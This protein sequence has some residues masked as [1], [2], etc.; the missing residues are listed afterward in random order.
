MSAAALAGARSGTK[1]Q[2][3]NTGSSSSDVAR[4]GRKNRAAR[5]RRKTVLKGLKDLEESS[6]PMKTGRAKFRI[7]CE[8][9]Q[10]SK[11]ATI[12]HTLFGLIILMSLVFMT[13]E[14]LNHDGVL[15]PGNLAPHQYKTMEMMF[16]VMFTIDLLFRMAIADRFFIKRRYPEHL[17]TH[18]PFFRDLLNWFDFLSILPLP[19]DFAIATV[20]EGSAVPKYIRLL[21]VFRVLRIFK[22]TRHFEGTKII[23]KTAQSSAAP[24]LVS[25]FMLLSFMFV[26]SPI[27]FFV[28]PCHVKDECVFHDAFN[29]MYYLMITLTTVGYGDQVCIFF[30]LYK[31]RN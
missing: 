27:L 26:V 16:T 8:S 11:G 31:K 12:F 15:F 10:S 6:P 17:E 13:G 29:S 30:F 2:P 18:L 20:Y 19:I 22:V 28:E 4:D 1:V 25:C 23:I 7:C 5:K 24:I 14:T 21:S 3:I 9:P